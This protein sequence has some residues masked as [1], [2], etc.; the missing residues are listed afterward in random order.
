[1]SRHSL[2]SSND[3]EFMES[4]SDFEHVALGEV[5][6]ASCGIDVD[7]KPIVDNMEGYEDAEASNDGG[8]HGGRHG[9]GDGK[10]G[11]GG[12]TGP[13]MMMLRKC[14][15]HFFFPPHN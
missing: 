12:M 10:G 11:R 2:S 3:E 15:L 14:I 5:I 8:S 6:T 13:V 9:K 4:A 1:M 7:A